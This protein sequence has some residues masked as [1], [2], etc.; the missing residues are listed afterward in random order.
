MAVALGPGGAGRFAAPRTRCRCPRNPGSVAIPG[1]PST[2]TWVRLPPKQPLRSRRST[3]TP[4]RAAPDRGEA[5]RSGADHETSAR[6]HLQGAG[7]LVITPS[8]GEAVMRSMYRG[9]DRRSMVSRRA[10]W[11]ATPCR[12]HRPASVWWVG[13]A[14]SRGSTTTSRFGTTK[15]GKSSARARCGSRPDAA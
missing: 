14:G 10:S 6:E 12:E 15:N 2:P 7:G 5:T 1:K 13:S 8:M 3:D 4:A 11:C 9:R